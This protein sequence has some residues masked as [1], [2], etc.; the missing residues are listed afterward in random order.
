LPRKKKESR[1]RR[2][3]KMRLGK[4]K[5]LRD[6]ASG[7]LGEISCGLLPVGVG[8][9]WDWGGGSSTVLK[10]SRFHTSELSTRPGQNEILTRMA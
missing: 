6:F 5:V 1:Q 7:I 9:G 3:E 4:K 2:G 8:V 10:I